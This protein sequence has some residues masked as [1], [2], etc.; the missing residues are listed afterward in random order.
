MMNTHW[1]V[2]PVDVNCAVAKSHLEGVL[3]AGS[4]AQPQEAESEPL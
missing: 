3:G 1:E 4:S 2:G